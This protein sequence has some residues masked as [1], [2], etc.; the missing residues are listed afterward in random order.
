MKLQQRLSIRE[1]TRCVTTLQCV[2]DVSLSIGVLLSGS[3]KAGGF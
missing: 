1:E 2:T 3:Q